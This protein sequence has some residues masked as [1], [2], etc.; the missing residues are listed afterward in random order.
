[1]LYT[2]LANHHFSSYYYC[3]LKWPRSFKSEVED[4][5]LE[6]PNLA[7]VSSA[8]LSP[9]PI[10]YGSNNED[11]SSSF[12]FLLFF[13]FLFSFLLLSLL[14]IT[15]LDWNLSSFTFSFS[16]PV[17]SFFPSFSSPLLFCGLW[18]CSVSCHGFR[19]EKIMRI[20]IL[21]KQSINGSWSL[22]WGISCHTS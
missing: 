19:R 8:L 2:F 7:P 22:V 21:G 9:L 6:V 5:T 12:S 20:R 4:L 3:G 13:S 16:F 14:S 17:S 10:C 1:M 18:I 11:S 15:P